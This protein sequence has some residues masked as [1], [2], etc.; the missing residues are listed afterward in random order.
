[1]GS[2]AI[3]NAKAQFGELIESARENGAQEITRNGKLVGVLISPEDWH[4]GTR[5][6][7]QNAR[8]TSEFFRKSPLVNSGLKLK[9][10]KAKMRKIAL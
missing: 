2:W 4:P 3:A 5:T 9:R 10:S 7:L 8:S 1:M 6:P